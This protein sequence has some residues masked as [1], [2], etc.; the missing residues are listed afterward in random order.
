MTK[1]CSWILTWVQVSWHNLNSII[2][3]L[4]PSVRLVLFCT[5]WD[6][7][8]RRSL[9]I[10][11]Y[12]TRVDTAIKFFLHSNWLILI[13][14][15]HRIASRLRTLGASRH[16]FHDLAEINF[17][18]NFSNNFRKCL[19]I[20]VRKI[21]NAMHQQIVFYWHFKTITT[22]FKE[23][24]FSPFIFHAVIC[25]TVIYDLEAEFINCVKEWK[26]REALEMWC[27]QRGKGL[28]VRIYHSLADFISSTWTLGD[29]LSNN[30]IQ[31]M[32]NYVT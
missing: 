19:N 2:F 5:D 15:S 18:W 22:P 12:L 11:W 32:T 28:N 23:K 14:T 30:L 25:K 6:D 21:E 4:E 24:I 9:F 3:K 29:L 13:G 26:R 20:P 7:M 27:W 8:R 17:A 16:S 31:W 10:E 1:F